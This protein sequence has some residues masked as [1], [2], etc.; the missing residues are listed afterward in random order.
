MHDVRGPTQAISLVHDLLLQGDDLTDP[1]LQDTL[2]TSSGRLRELLDLLDQVLRLPLP[3]P[4]PEPLPVRQLV[5]HLAALHATRHGPVGFDY[6]GT[7]T[8]PL[9]AVKGV[10]DRIEHALL[11]LFLN[12]HE[13]LG[14]GRGSAIRLSGRA[15]SNGRR[16][17]LVMEDD[18]PGV[19]AEVRDRLFQPFVT[20]KQGRPMAGLGLAVAK[21]LV[22]EAGGGVRHEPGR[23]GARFVVEL[24]AW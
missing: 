15:A 16:V 13:A 11:N 14:E 12:A 7:L 19:P 21:M 9:P 1:M 10:E 18:G 24:P 17:E 20:T 4:E 23:S 3:G 8:P 22:E 2:R 5:E 6:S